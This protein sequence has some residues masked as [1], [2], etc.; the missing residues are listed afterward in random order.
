MVFL[1]GCNPYRSKGITQL[2]PAESKI[3]DS[4]TEFDEFKEADIDEDPSSYTDTPKDVYHVK[5]V[6]IVL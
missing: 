5:Y 3:V 2:P 6:H 4:E 1:T